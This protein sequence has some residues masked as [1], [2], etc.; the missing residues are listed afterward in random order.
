MSFDQVWPKPVLDFIEMWL[1]LAQNYPNGRMEKYIKCR[2]W[3]SLSTLYSKFFH[4]KSSNGPFDQVWPKS[5]HW[6]LQKTPFDGTLDGPK[7]KSHEYKVCYT[8][9]VLHFV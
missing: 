6:F 3:W 8:H 5:K 7:W 2:S 1:G 4:L 9:Q